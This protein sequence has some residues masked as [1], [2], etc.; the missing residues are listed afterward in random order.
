MTAVTVQKALRA[1]GKRS[2]AASAYAEFNRAVFRGC[3][4]E[5][6]TISWNKR[7]RTTAGLTYT[8][9]R[10]VGG[11]VEYSARIELAE[12]VLTDAHRVRSTLLHEMCHAAAWL[13]DHVHRPPHGAAFKAWAAKASA[14]YPHYCVKTCHSYEIEYKHKYKCQACGAEYGRHSKSINVERQRCGA[15]RG[16]LQYC[17]PL[18]ADGTPAK[19]RQASAFSKYVSERYKVVKAS[20]GIGAKHAQVMKALGSEWKAAKA[21]R[22]AV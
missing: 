9:R 19:P 4:P 12:K 3:L 7:L 15:C 1:A 21:L 14:V 18:A 11:R 10:A 5:N 22:A 16:Q 8:S 2:V 6:M 13:V 17:A 20:L